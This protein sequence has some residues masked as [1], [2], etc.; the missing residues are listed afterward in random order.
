CAGFRSSIDSFLSAVVG[1]FAGHPKLDLRSGGGSAG[2][3][4]APS[5]ALGSLTH[6]GKTEVSLPARTGESRINATTV[7]ANDHAQASCGVVDVHFDLLRLRMTESV[8][9]SFAADSVHLIADQG[10]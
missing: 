6:A 2:D 7:I 4:D 3:V 1:D 10:V 9:D 5:N 8:H